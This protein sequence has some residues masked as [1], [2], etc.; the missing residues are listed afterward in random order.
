MTVKTAM[1]ML[2]DEGIVIR[3]QGKGTFVTPRTE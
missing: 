1:V 3:I 2:A